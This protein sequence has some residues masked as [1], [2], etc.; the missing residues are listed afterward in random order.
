MTAEVAIM[1]QHA[2]VLA[3]DSATTVT[4]WVQGEKKAR[5]FKGANKLYQL[6]NAHPVGLMIYGSA[7]LEDVPWELIVK[8]FRKTSGNESSSR[9]NEYARRFFDFVK[10]HS[11]LFPEEGKLKAFHEKVKQA[12]YGHLLWVADIEE[13]KTADRQNPTLLLELLVKHLQPRLDA[14]K[15]AVP[16]APITPADVE[17]A[18]A[19]HIDAATSFIPEILTAF[20]AGTFGDVP[21]SVLAELAIRT[22][23]CQYRVFSSETGVVVGGYGEEEFFPSFEVYKCFGFLDRHFIANRDPETSNAISAEVPAAIEPFATTSMISMFRMGMGQDVYAAIIR[24]TRGALK[25]FAE[26]V[27]SAIDPQAQ[28]SNLDDLLNTAAKGCTDEW[29][30]TSLNNHF[31]PFSRVIASLPI[32]DMAG[33]AKSLIELESLKE[34]VTDSSESVSGPIDVAAITKHDGFVWI[35]RKHYFRPELN[36]RYFSRQ[37]AKF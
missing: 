20:P 35:E 25:A 1:N 4:M 6:S 22:V 13:V 27:R 15:S 32:S 24:A 5:Y 18:V 21:A 31:W 19:A 2:L 23:L 10:G 7:S 3:A 16:E 33:L 12:A 34:R 11:G 36:P 8:E 30:R 26:T 9:L 17:A 37:S 28:I 29:F 14:L